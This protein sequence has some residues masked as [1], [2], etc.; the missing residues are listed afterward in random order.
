M[1]YRSIAL[2]IVTTPRYKEPNGINTCVA[3]IS[4]KNNIEDSYLCKKE[5]VE[6]GFGISSETMVTISALGSNCVFQRPDG[7]TKGCA[8]DGKYAAIQPDGTPRLRAD[9]AGG[10]AV[11]G[12][13]FY[14]KEGGEIKRRDISKF[15]P[16][17]E[18]FTVKSVS[19]YPPGADK[20]ARIIRVSLSKTNIP[21]AG[22]KFFYAHGQKGTISRLVPAYDMPF[23]EYGRMAGQ[24]PD[25][26]INV[27][28]FARVTMGFLLEI[29]WSKAAAYN[30]S[31]MHQ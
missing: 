25:I 7:K 19:R 28:S 5:A 16:W 22:D 23:F 3:V 12:K 30:A 4:H 26:V 13:T 9:L 27:A 20:P 14:K 1:R 18:N 24:S 6:R 21:T 10:D 17:N 29:M 15:L 11:I 8:A 2:S 31:R